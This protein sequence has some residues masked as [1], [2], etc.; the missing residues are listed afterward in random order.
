MFGTVPLGASGGK[1]WRSPYR[2]SGLGVDGERAFGDS[3]TD[4]EQAF[5]EH[6]FTTT[7]CHTP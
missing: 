7:I 2:R 5:R 3:L 1:N 6:P 4:I